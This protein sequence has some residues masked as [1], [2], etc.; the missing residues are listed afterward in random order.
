MRTTPSVIPPPRIDPVPPGARRPFWS[1]MIPTYNCAAYLRE[2]LQS[3][4][5]QDPG[6]DVMEIEVIDDRSTKDDP[7]VVVQEL[8]RGRVRFYRQ[9]QNQ[10][11][12]GNFNTCI[13]RASGEWLHILHGDDAV[14]PGFYAHAQ[15]AIGTHPDL[16]AVTFR[17]LNIDEDSMWTHL[18]EFEARRPGV[19]GEHFT[20]RM[21]LSNR[22]MFPAMTVRRRVY[23]Q[24]GG[25]RPELVHCA[26]WDM[27]L[28][29]TLNFPVYYDPE[30][31]AL[32]RVHS[33]AD[34]ARLM[35][36]GENVVDERRF[37]RI[38]ASYVP[39]ARAKSVYRDGLNAAAIRALRCSRD[40]WRKQ[41]YAV[42]RVQF[43]EAMRCGLTPTVLKH[44]LLT[45]AWV[46]VA[47]ADRPM[48]A[49]PGPGARQAI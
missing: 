22:I 16:G 7:E 38:M 13:R 27:W 19:L 25:F 6:P 40:L 43:R 10:G 49:D 28:R 12:M 3:V 31:L 32:Y 18:T 9:P 29:T 33:A 37:M 17:Y 46:M 30:P 5:D 8:G 20:A 2:T 42:A 45:L 41:K 36:T 4:L 35:T 15:W 48:T 23:E 21:L 39:P 1:V 47:S 26:D 14:R 34:T 24:L 11:P 44:V